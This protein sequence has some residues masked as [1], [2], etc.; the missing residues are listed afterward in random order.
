MEMILSLWNNWTTYEKLATLGLILVIMLVIPACIWLFTKHSKLALVSL[1]SLLIM[2]LMIMLSF[3]V[4]N[5]IFNV[6]IIF[7]YKLVPFIVLFLNIL[8]LGTMTGYFMQNHKHRDFDTLSMKT[9][10]L[11]DTFALTIASLLLFTGFSVLTPSLLIPILL[12]L[13]LSLGSIWINYALL[14]K[15]LK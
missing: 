4:L 9:E 3:V 6:T 7:I 14:Y 8:S 13:G 2:G 15:L 10:M 1:L 5:Q 11:K 12:S